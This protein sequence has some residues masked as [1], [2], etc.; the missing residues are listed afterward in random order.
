MDMHGDS[1]Q[2]IPIVMMWSFLF[3]LWQVKTL[4]YHTTQS[5]GQA[6]LESYLSPMSWKIQLTNQIFELNR[7]THSIQYIAVW[8]LIARARAWEYEFSLI[9]D[10]FKL[11]IFLESRR[12]GAHVPLLN[13]ATCPKTFLVMLSFWSYIFSFFISVPC[14]SRVI[15]LD[16]N[17]SAPCPCTSAPRHS[18]LCSHFGHIFFHFSFRSHAPH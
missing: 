18:W 5:Q 14:P 2:Y 4:L 9:F 1:I 16:K 7:L 13:S 11:K 12:F 17:I 6:K 8:K 15:Y 3:L 10:F